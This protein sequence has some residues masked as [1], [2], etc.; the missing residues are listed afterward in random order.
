MAN[1]KTRARTL[2]LLGRQQIA[3]IPT[4]INELLKNAH[5]AYADKVDIDYFRL[6]GLFVL[7]DDGIGMTRNDFE[8]RWLT[9]GTESKT[10]HRR[11]SP[12]P[13][14]SSKTLR[15]PMGEK[16]IGR[17]AIASIGKQVLIVTKAKGHP[18]ITAAL[19]NWQIFELPGLN[20]EDI[21]VP[22]KSFSSL[23]DMND[24]VSMK[25]ELISSIDKLLV[26]DDISQEEYKDILLTVDSFDVSPKD[27]NKQLVRSEPFDELDSGGTCFYV[28]SVEDV[29]KFDLDG[30]SNAKD[31]TK[32]EKMLMGFH[33]TMTPEHPEP[34]L[35]IVFRDYRSEDGT[36]TDVI[37]KEHFF[38][39]EDFKLA[40]HHIHGY[41]DEFGQFKG[42]IKIYR[43]K[44]F[45]HI[46]NWRG[47][48]LNKTSCGS[49][50]VNLAYIQG[51]KKDSIIDLENHSRLIAKTDKFGGLYVYKDNIRILP[52]GDSDYDFLEFEKRRSK[53]AAQA[54]FLIEECLVS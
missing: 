30:N 4:A 54:F 40:D 34:L 52:Y 49:F 44:T 39:I 53:H 37:D 36:Y 50:E 38:T 13:I 41:F 19:I 47:N 12:P 22:V 31:A 18:Q 26:Q 46:I 15:I 42:S 20:L 6:K 27:L 2:D 24:I 21:V 14:D 5:D 16:G 3:G 32:I 23:P 28:S 8:T 17:L 51:T 35:D 33:N 9:L 48:N 29:L 43:E 1:F 25:N 10:N 45:E 11:S 7:R